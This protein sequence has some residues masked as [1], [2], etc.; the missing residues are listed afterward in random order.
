MQ[1][2]TGIR[3][4]SGKRIASVFTEVK[5]KTMYFVVKDPYASPAQG[6]VL[7]EFKC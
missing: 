2:K 1:S 4:L 6:V 5:G 7:R 3:T